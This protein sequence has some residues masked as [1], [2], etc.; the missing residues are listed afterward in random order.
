[1]YSRFSRNNDRHQ[2]HLRRLVDFIN[3]FVLFVLIKKRRT[4]TETE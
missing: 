1:M 2:Y 3:Q 4:T